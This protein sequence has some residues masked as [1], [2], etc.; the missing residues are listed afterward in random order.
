MRFLAWLVGLL[1]LLAGA[2]VGAAYVFDGDLRDRVEAEVAADLT[3]S[4]PLV[5]PEVAI[6]GHPIA[7][8][9]LQR[10]FPEVRVAAAAMPLQLPAGPV[11]LADLDVTLTDVTPDP[12]AVRAASLEGTARLPYD[13]V[14]LLAGTPILHA[15]GDRLA[16]S[17]SVEVLGMTVTG[18]LSAVPRLDVDTQTIG[19]DDPEVDVAGV[20][21]PEA[22]VEALVERLWQPVVLDLPYGLELDAVAAAPG[23]LEVGVR[24]TDVVL[25]AA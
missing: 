16:A 18:T 14:G 8:H 2:V 12:D 4:V 13:D 9:L 21:I 7:W 22:A 17:G 19:L 10:R 1:V 6:E 25:P 24:G 20:R 5:E 3:T 23:G 11:E 15:G